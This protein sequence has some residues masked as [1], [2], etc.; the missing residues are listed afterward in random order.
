MADTSP[1]ITTYIPLLTTLVVAG[2]NVVL[3]L[4]TSRYVRLTGRIVE[5]SQK[6]REPFVTVDFELP[7]HTLRLVVENHGLTSARNVRIEVLRD[8]DWLNAGKGRTGIIH[9]GPVNEGVSYLTPSRK[10]KYLL[11]FPKW[12]DTPDDAMEASMRITYQNDK[13]KDYENT[14]D[15][16]FGQMR[17]VL[18][19]SFKDS[20]L[21][22]ADAIK[23]PSAQGSRMTVFAHQVP[24][25]RSRKRA[26]C[27]LKSSLG[28]RRSV[29]TAVTSLRKAAQRA[30]RPDRPWLAPGYSRSVDHCGEC[31]A[32]WQV[33]S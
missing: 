30:D 20:N 29:H 23:E 17:D 14:V 7:D 9:C 33:R 1:W 27:V 22:V 2:A 18:F 19:E 8:V 4:L 15:F 26:P 32:T 13:G 6:S 28:P 21:A 25:S 5:E 11:G 3:V 16:D 31:G 24:S 12:K 10:L